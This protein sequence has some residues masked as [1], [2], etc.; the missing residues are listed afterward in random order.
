MRAIGGLWRWRHNPL[1]RTTDLLEAWLALAA[2]VLILLA[3]PLAGTLVGT[4]AQDALQR[5]VQDQRRDRQ[6][7]AATVVRALAP[8]PLDLDPETAAARDRYHRVV[9]DWT[10]PDG[11][12]QHGT[13]TATLRDPRPGD[14]FTL[15]TDERGRLVGRP[16]DT[17]TATTHAV[18]AGLGTALGAAVSVEGARRLIVWHMVRRRYARW[19]R[20]WGTAG[21]DWGRTG[22][23]S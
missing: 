11:T 17:S 9:A 19:D 10:A 16:L 12:E 3:A 15:W 4:A 20:A 13:V 14:R 7:V 2:L 5:S 23:G 22:T 18:L 1:R 21:P 8:S 6:Q